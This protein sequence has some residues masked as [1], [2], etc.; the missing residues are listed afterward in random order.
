MTTFVQKRV[1]DLSDADWSLWL[2]I[3][4]QSAIYGSPYF[5][6]E[7]T[8]AAAAVRQD[9]EIAA[10]QEHGKTVGFWPFQRGKLSLGRPIG[11]K[12]SDF[13]GPI[14]RPGTQFDPLAFL[15]AA[16]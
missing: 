14:V 11:G 1:C 4:R 5:R 8:R 10:I 15:A 7:F 2:E 3:Q 12:M 16:N 6:P 9:V 13:H